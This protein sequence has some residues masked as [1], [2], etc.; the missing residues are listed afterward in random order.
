MNELLE[1]TPSRGFSRTTVHQQYNRKAFGLFMFGRLMPIVLNIKRPGNL[2]IKGVL[3][4]GDNPHHH[5]PYKDLGLAEVCCENVFAFNVRHYIK[6]F[7]P[8]VIDSNGDPQIPYTYNL[9]QVCGASIVDSNGHSISSI[10][11]RE[12]RRN[13]YIWRPNKVLQEPS[14]RTTP[15]QTYQRI[16]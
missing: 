16:V 9:C 10:M 4:F 14:S 1:G 8:Q 5:S 3:I 11:K 6:C 13:A 15:L 12:F 7:L 2:Y